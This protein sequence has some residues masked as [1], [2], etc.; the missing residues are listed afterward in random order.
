MRLVD[1]FSKNMAPVVQKVERDNQMKTHICFYDLRASGLS[2]RGLLR[3]ENEDAFFLS[4]DQGLYLVSDGMGG[5]KAGGLASQM[6]AQVLPLQVQAGS[7]T[8]SIGGGVDAAGRLLS[9]SIGIVNEMLLDKTRDL[10]E[11]QGLGATVTSLLKTDTGLALAHLGDSR[12]YLMRRGFLE[13]LTKDH[14]VADLLLEAGQIS[15]RQFRKHPGRNM[16][17]RHIGMKDCPAP[18]A[19]VLH[20]R[21]GDRLLLCTDGLSGMLKDREIGRILWETPDRELACRQLIERA[22][23]EGGRDN[24]TVAILDVVRPA[25]RKGK[26]RK[27]V[28]VR[29]AVGRSTENIVPEPD[30]WIEE[31]K[32]EAER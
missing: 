16:L 27:K 12:A 19:A 23:E 11:A 8:Q 28:V 1:I 21:P 18:D 3:E 15:R 20:V 31:K 32:K 7:L 13:R 24:I 22:N 30:E 9:S 2:D 26:R 10:P 29:R 4:E 17:T 5:Q 6:V 14:T 25:P